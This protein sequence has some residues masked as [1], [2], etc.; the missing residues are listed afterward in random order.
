MIIIIQQSLPIMT[1]QNYNM[2]GNECVNP[3]ALQLNIAYVLFRFSTFEDILKVKI[4]N[5]QDQQ[6]LFINILKCIQFITKLK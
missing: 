4:R 1:N 5:D 2:N 6:F 3:T